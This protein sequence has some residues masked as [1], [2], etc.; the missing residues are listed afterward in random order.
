VTLCH[1]ARRPLFGLLYEPRMINDDNDESG[2]ANGMRIGKGHISIERKPASVTLSATNLT[3]PRLESN[4]NAGVRGR[5][6][7]D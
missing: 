6:L 1:F 4:R 5:H 2:A 3:S 7:T